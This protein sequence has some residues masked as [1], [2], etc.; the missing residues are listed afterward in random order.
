MS[1]TVRSD[2]PDEQALAAEVAA[3]FGGVDLGNGVTWLEAESIDNY[4]S[5]AERAAARRTDVS[6]GGWLTVSDQLFDRF[7]SAVTFL[8]AHGFRYYL[9]AFIVADIRR[10]GRWESAVDDGVLARLED[11][12]RVADL[13]P[14]LHDRQ[15]RA[16]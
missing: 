3:A 4:E 8:D 12:S 16:V 1:D 13:L 10:G 15:R 2:L 6:A 11:P 7:P 9:P 14:L 5:P